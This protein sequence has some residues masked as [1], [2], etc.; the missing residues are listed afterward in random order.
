MLRVTID[1][2]MSCHPLGKTWYVIIDLKRFQEKGKRFW[3]DHI[4]MQNKYCKLLA[5]LGYRE[6]VICFVFLFFLFFVLLLNLVV[7]IT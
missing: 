5:S 3:E 4:A 6:G 7:D 1:Q 2:Y